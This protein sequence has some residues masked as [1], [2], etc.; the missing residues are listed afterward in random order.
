MKKSILTRNSIEAENHHLDQKSTCGVQN[1]WFK[2]PTCQNG[3]TKSSESTSSVL[4]TW[5]TKSFTSFFRKQQTD[6]RREEDL[7]ERVPSLCYELFL[8]FECVEKTRQQA[9]NFYKFCANLKRNYGKKYG[10]IIKKM[11]QMQSLCVLSVF[12]ITSSFVKEVSC[13]RWDLIDVFGRSER[14]L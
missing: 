8:Y 5:F 7:D 9:C 14:T 4:S 10:K 2:S 11:K 12:S 1:F 3:L 13:N 6:G